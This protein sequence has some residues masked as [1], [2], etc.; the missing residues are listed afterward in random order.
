[1][2]RRIDDEG[3]EPDLGRFETALLVLAFLCSLAWVPPLW[4]RLRGRA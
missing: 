4:R 2:T 3:A 1:M